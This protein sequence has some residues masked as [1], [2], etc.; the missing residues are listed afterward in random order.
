MYIWHRDNYKAEKV[1]LSIR[2]IPQ[3]NEISTQQRENVFANDDYH[4][5]K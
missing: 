3:Y 5:D 4:N 2:E 1:P